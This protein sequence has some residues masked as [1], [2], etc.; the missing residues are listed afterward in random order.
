[1]TNIAKYLFAEE[2]AET[3]K[4]VGDICGGLVG[5]VFSYKDWMNPEERPY[6]EKYLAAREGIPTEHRLKV[7]RMIKDMGDHN[8]DEV[9]IHAEGSIAAQ[10]MAIY[11]SA[12]WERYKAA[13]KRISGIPGWKSHPALKDL[14][15]W[16]YKF[17]L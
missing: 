14:P 5:T 7:I 3:T 11:G 2:Q 13:A 17:Q 15:D 10:K 9:F 4:T 6:I 12:D 8:L 1:M 16:P